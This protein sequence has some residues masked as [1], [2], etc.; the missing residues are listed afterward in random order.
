[1]VV[2]PAEALPIK[3]TLIS[4]LGVIFI[5][6]ILSLDMRRIYVLVGSYVHEYVRIQSIALYTTIGREDIGGQV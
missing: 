5:V 4:K 3:A 2:F 1:M 6:D